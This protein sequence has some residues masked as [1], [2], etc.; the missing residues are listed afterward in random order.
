MRSLT[1]QEIMK[2]FSFAQL[3][4]LATLGALREDALRGL[5]GDGNVLELARGDTLFTAGSKPTAFYVILQ[6]QI[7]VHRQYEGQAKRIRTHKRGEQ[8]GFAAI[9]ALHDRR[10]TA[11][12]DEP[13]V[14][15]E[16]STEHFQRL[17]AEAS[18]DFAVLMMNLAR[19]M[20]RTINVMGAD[21]AKL[22]GSS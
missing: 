22:R 13:S 20:A 19:G 9:I 3:Q 15:L 7:S 5:L 18:E 17:Y 1:E 8:I 6:G 11:I 12:T 21:I 2:R 14:V 16:I 4:E 10:G